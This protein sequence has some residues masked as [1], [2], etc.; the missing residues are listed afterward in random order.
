[1]KTV[2]LKVVVEDSH[3]AEALSDELCKVME[4][5][6]GFVFGL[7]VKDSSRAETKAA[8]QSQE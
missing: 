1:M 5:E 3:D 7:Y 6:S 8:K 2:T 4:Y